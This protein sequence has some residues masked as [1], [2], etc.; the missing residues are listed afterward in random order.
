MASDNFTTMSLDK[1][2]PQATVVFR[3]ETLTWLETAS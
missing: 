1:I 2:Q 3:R